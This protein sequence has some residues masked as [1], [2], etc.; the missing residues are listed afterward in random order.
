VVANGGEHYC[1]NL[2][3]I[4]GVGH[5]FDPTL[6]CCLKKQAKISFTR[7]KVTIDP[8]TNFTQTYHLKER[9]ES[10]QGVVEI[11]VGILP[12]IVHDKAARPIRYR[13][14][15]QSFTVPVNAFVKSSSEKLHAHHAKD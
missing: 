4:S 3:Y 8:Q 5:N 10:S 6:K 7:R 11:D 12:G 15:R 2:R 9:K 1:T 14:V 13:S